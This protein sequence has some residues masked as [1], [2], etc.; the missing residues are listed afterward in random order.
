MSIEGRNIWEN[1]DSLAISFGS[2]RTRVETQG[3]TS[4]GFRPEETRATGGRRK[5]RRSEAVRVRADTIHGGHVVAR[6]LIK[7]EAWRAGSWGGRG[8]EEEVADNESKSQQRS[9]L[10]PGPISEDTAVRIR[11]N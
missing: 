9:G 8:R 6:G 7:F 5:P 2:F 3:A 4:R 1:V 10:G 11:P